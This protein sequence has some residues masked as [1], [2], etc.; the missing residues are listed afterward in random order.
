MD[1]QPGQVTGSRAAALEAVS[2]PRS[3]ILKTTITTNRDSR[4]VCTETDGDRGGG[5]EGQLLY[6]FSQQCAE[7][8]LGTGFLPTLALPFH[9]ITWGMSASGVKGPR[10]GLEILKI[11]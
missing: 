11:T 4:C 9:H 1:C 7:G 6:P 2:V 5:Q 10:R 3:G 8:Q